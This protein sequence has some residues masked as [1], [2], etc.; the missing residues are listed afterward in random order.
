[1]IFSIAYLPPVEFF[2]YALKPD[3]ITIEAC[4]NFIKQTYRNRCRIYGANG[5]LDLS[6][7]L[8]HC[9]RPQ[10]PLKEVKISYNM[11]W[12]KIHWRTI[13]AAYNKSAYFLYYRDNFEKFFSGNYHWLIEFN[14]DILTECLK[15]LK[16][17]KKVVYS[18]V[19]N[20]TYEADDLRMKINP[21]N[22]PEI[23]FQPYTQVFDVKYG[24]LSNL[25]I[26]DLL[27]NC[28]PDS[29]EYLESAAKSL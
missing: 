6:I 4:E 29:L 10:L 28:G 17:D 2:V 18:D 14:H 26:I 16:L 24:F 23:I 7:P 13:T 1:V 11:P 22:I 8:E 20:K 9:R 19:F 5:K 15:L 27:F 25:S 21:K 3:E 12:N